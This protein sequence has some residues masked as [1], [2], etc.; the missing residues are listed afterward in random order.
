M[1]KMLKNFASVGFNVSID[2]A[3]KKRFE[4]LRHGADWNEVRDNLDYYH[5]LHINKRAHVGITCTVS[6][7]NVM[8]L[9]E[10]HSIF[11]DRWPEFRIFHNTAFYPSWYNPSVFPEECKPDIVKPLVE[12]TYAHDYIQRDIDGIVKFVLTPRKETVKPYGDQPTDTVESEIA[13]RWRMF[14]EQVVAGDV[15]RK[16]NFRECFPE[17]YTILLKNKKMNY[18]H[19]H[20]IAKLNPR[21]GALEAGKVI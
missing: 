9:A 10:F 17:L 1:N 2:S 15:Y 18:P 8:Y 16:E 6:A 5:E 13:V 7:L 12:A 4:Y 11:A 20:N 14:V 21:Y 3:V 19:E